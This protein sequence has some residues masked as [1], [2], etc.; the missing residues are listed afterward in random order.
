MGA[1]WRGSLWPSPDTSSY[2]NK[3]KQV[4]G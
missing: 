4:A 3:A 1:D 2:E